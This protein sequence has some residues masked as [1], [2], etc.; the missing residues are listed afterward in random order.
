ML[1]WTKWFFLKNL[2]FRFTFVFAVKLG[3][4]EYI[5]C[6]T[7]TIMISYR[8]VSVSLLPKKHALLHQ[9]NSP[10]SWI[11]ATNVYNL[12]SFIFF[13]AW[14]KWNHTI[15]SLFKL[16]SFIS[17]HLRFIH[18]ASVLW[19]HFF[20]FLFFWTVFHST[21][22]TLPVSPFTYWHFWLLPVLLTSKAALNIC[23][24]D[25]V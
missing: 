15:C 7:S 24:Q 4:D 2:I 21:D 6:Y 18:T 5:Q 3:F 10:S 19:V 25:L 20:S 12:Y 22:V 17:M 8:T 14:Y 9:F 23:T 16:A 11:M 1:W 13:R